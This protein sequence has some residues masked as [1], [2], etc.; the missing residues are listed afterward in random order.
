MH[1]QSFVG[2]LYKIN[3]RPDPND[4][5]ESYRYDLSGVLEIVMLE[6]LSSLFDVAWKKVERLACH[7]M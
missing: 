3:Q 5:P 1:G 2:F 4:A 6:R 7:V